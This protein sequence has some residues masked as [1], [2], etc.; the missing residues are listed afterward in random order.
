MVLSYISGK[1]L[2]SEWINNFSQKGDQPPDV[3]KEL[4][5]ICCEF[6]DNPVFFYFDFEIGW[7]H[8]ISWITQMLCGLFLLHYLGIVI[9]SHIVFSIICE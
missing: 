8:L 5:K 1:Q 6:S 9:Y 2:I 4:E 7:I 3:E